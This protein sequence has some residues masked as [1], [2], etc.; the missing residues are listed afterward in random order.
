MD[1]VEVFDKR[2]RRTWLIKFAKSYDGLANQINSAM[3]SDAARFFF[4]VENRQKIGFLRCV[5]KSMYFD[6]PPKTVFS[7]SDAYVKAVS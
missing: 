1:I 3:Y 2:E 4:A 5:D 7:A 6:L